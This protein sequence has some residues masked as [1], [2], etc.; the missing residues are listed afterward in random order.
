MNTLGESVKTQELFDI[1]TRVTTVGTYGSKVVDA[2][3][4]KSSVV[5]LNSA[6]SSGGSSVTLD[7]KMQTSEPVARGLDDSGATEDNDVQL[8][9]AGASNI[10]LGA[11]FTQSGG[12]QIKSVFLRLKKEGTITSG[13]VVTVEIQGDSGGNKPDDTLV[14]AD[15]TATVETDDIAAAF[16]WVEFELT[17]PVDLATSTA[18]WIVLEGDYTESTTNCIT[19]ATDTV[20]SGGN[21]NYHDAD[22]TGSL[23]TTQTV[24]AFIEQYNFEDVSGAE[25]DT[26]DELAASFQ[27]L[28]MELKSL[29]RYLRALATV[30]V[31]SASFIFGAEIAL[32]S[33]QVEPVSG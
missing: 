3:G 20:A 5:S 18:Y 21:F 14:H 6:K 19:L 13:K 1:A 17:R 27:S 7:V 30:A 22:W 32:G 12:R 2:V 4:F 16:G 8:R 24:L 9:D 23:I 31:S 33:A 15:A 29:D 25:F 10:E 26:V 11:K 28:D